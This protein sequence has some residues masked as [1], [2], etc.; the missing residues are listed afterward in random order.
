MRW[1]SV[2]VDA[3]GDPGIVLIYKNANNVRYTKTQDPFG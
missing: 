3:D 1:S 2:E